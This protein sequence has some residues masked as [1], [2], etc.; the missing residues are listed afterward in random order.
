MKAILILLLATATAFAQGW[1]TTKNGAD[2]S[3]GFV[4][5]VE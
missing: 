2:V 1:T 5:W 4:G 3:A